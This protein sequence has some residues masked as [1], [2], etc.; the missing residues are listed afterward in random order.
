VGSNQDQVV[1]RL[2]D[3]NP[4]DI[5]S[6]EVLK[7]AAATAIYGSRAT[8]GVVVITTKKGSAGQ[9][10]WNVTQRVGTQQLMRSLGHRQYATLTDVL[11]FVGGPVG[12]A[13]ARAACTPNCT[14]YDWQG[15]LYGRTDPSYETLISSSG[16]SG[17]TRYF[18]SLNDRQE[19]GIMINTG[20]RRTGGRINLDQTLGS[21]LTASMGLD[22]TQLPAARYRQQQQRRCQPHV[23]VRLHAGDH[24][25]EH[26]A[27][28]RP[29]PQHA[30]LRRRR[31]DRESV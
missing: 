16:G 9:P 12:E 4:N 31:G 14:N 17:N 18:A 13:A 15:Q 20:A 8:N 21:K 6:V 28:E 5:E 26:Q 22:V 27:C 29:L 3:L 30:L 10:K 11:P 1:N 19:S 7:S 24:R 23:R 2:A 25:P